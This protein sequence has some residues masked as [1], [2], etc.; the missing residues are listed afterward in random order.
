MAA[1]SSQ[2]GLSFWGYSGVATSLWK[3][4]KMALSPEE[5]PTFYEDHKE[6]IIVSR[7]FLSW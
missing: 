6:L 3:G 2:G 7:L 1:N 4:A 5:K